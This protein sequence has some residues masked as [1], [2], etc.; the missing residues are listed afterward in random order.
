[1]ILPSNSCPL[2]FPN[3]DASNFN[4]QF[5]NPVYLDGEWEVA[6]IDFT[7]VYNSFPYYSNSLLRYE[8][9]KS[10]QVI[11]Y[12]RINNQNK[13]YELIN[14][15]FIPN[16]DM[17]IENY[18]NLVIFCPRVPFKVTFPYTQRAFDFGLNSKSVISEDDHFRI[19]LPK[20]TND[21]IIEQIDINISY[22]EITKYEKYFKDELYLETLSELRGY[23]LTFNPSPFKELLIQN[24]ELVKITLADNISNITFDT[25]LVKS[26][27]LNKQTFTDK[28]I[29][30]TKIPKLLHHHQ[31]MFIYSNI[32][33]PINVGDVRVPLLKSIWIKKY[34]QGE[35]VQLEMKNPMYIPVSYS[36]INIIEVN[37]R[38]DSGKLI[39]FN[40]DTKT[41]LSLHFRKINV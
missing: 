24:N 7:F 11:K 31:Q 38:D 3:N 36:T 10:V 41:H 2:I 30:G 28:N 16:C 40:K 22:D 32:I 14:N 1:M 13:T 9:S 20:F 4:V 27:G 25:N 5:Q 19:K 17:Y 8:E 26:L 35:I 23:L 37:I 15:Q 6:L 39:K 18:E 12:L 33:E 21:D 34:D 29:V